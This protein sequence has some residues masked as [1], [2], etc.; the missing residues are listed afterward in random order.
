MNN[1]NPFVTYQS[2]FN[3][4][5]FGLP[6]DDSI[7]RS[8]CTFLRKSSPDC[9][10]LDTNFHRY[11]MSHGWS[12]AFHKFFLHTHS[13][14]YA[15]KQR[16][17]PSIES[18]SILIPIH[19]NTCHWVALVWRSINNTVYFLYSGDMNLHNVADTIRYSYSRERTSDLFHPLDAVWINCNSFTYS[20]HGSRSIL[21]LTVMSCHHYAAGGLLSAS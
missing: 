3:L 16:A 12:L 6:T 21:A 5:S 2:F 18:P 19:V 13:T 15:K 11:F 10:T 7:F 1:I 9:Y 20:P 17:K 4:L 8:Y 14:N